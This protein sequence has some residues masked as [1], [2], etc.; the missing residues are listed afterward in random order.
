MLGLGKLAAAAAAVVFGANA[1]LGG[2]AVISVE[3][4]PESL[5]A[6]S[7]YRLEFTVR[8]HGEEP[9]SGL[10]PNVRLKGSSASFAAMPVAQPG[11]Y[12]ATITVPQGERVTLVVESGWGRGRMAELTLMPIPVLRRGQA[13]AVQRPADRGRHL[14]VAKGCG[15]CHING[16]VP[17][18]AAENESHKLGPELTGRRLEAQYVRQRLTDPRS[19]PAIGEGPVR[20][21]DLGLAEPEVT[22]L[23]ALLTGPRESASH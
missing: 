8:Q 6:G 14:F 13:L 1:A 12:A 3:N 20:M 15:T 4:L 19:L 16:D 10:K 5:L 9:L 23:V 2:W 21:P 18:F 22:A 11:R 7:A 17:E